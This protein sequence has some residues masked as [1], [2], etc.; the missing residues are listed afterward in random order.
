MCRARVGFNFPKSASWRTV[1]SPKASALRP[2][3]TGPGDPVGFVH[4]CNLY[5]S[6]AH[7]GDRRAA[8]RGASQRG[9]DAPEQF[10]E[11]TPTSPSSRQPQGR[12]HGRDL[13]LRYR[14]RRLLQ[15]FILLI[16]SRHGAHA[17]GTEAPPHRPHRFLPKNPG[18]VNW[19]NVQQL[20]D[21]ARA[22]P[23]RSGLED[24]LSR[25]PGASPAP[26][27]R[28]AT[29]L[30]SSAPVHTLP[31][32]SQHAHVAHGNVRGLAVRLWRWMHTLTVGGCE[33]HSGADV[34]V[35]GA[36]DVRAAGSTAGGGPAGSLSPGVAACSKRNCL[37]PPRPITNRGGGAAEIG[38]KPL[39]EFAHTD[40]AGA[41][42]NGDGLRALRTGYSCTRACSLTTTF[43]GCIQLD[44]FWLL[45]TC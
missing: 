19:L 27:P 5:W 18:D 45:C 24:A 8:R 30:P 2:W 44:W 25:Q 14:S 1:P 26:T 12:E 20:S 31:Q 28:A 7:P 41:S 34:C 3:H 21:L 33:G 4:G 35:A 38:R 22:P 13:T 29:A 10:G 37:P 6:L 23:P 32:S 15:L 9:P 17:V 42:G 43:A 36:A 16:F 11:T 40:P 39:A